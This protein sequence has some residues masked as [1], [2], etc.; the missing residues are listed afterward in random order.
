MPT[1]QQSQQEVGDGDNWFVGFASRLDPSNIPEKM[2]QYSSNMRLQRGTAAARLGATRLTGSYYGQNALL[3]YNAVGTYIRQ[4]DGYEFMAV[5]GFESLVLFNQDGSV[6]Q[7][8]PYF[9]S[10]GPTS[11]NGVTIPL[12][13]NA[14]IVQA[15][16][17]LYIF[18]GQAKGNPVS[19]TFTNAAI[20]AGTWGAITVVGLNVVGLDTNTE[21][22][23]QSAS[24]TNAYHVLNGAYT[25]QDPATNFPLN[26]LVI[27]WY[28]NTGSTFNAHTVA[29]NGMTI[30]I[31]Y[32]PLVWDLTSSTVNVV[33]QNFTTGTTANV[34]PSDFAI[35]YQNRLVCKNGDHNIAVSDILSDTFDLTFN[36]F[37]VNVGSADGVVGF[38]PWINNQMVVFM[39]KSVYLCYFDPTVATTGAPGVNSS[40]TVIT[41]EIGC[42]ARRTIVNAGNYVFF[43]SAKGVYML[44]PQLDMKLVGNT[45]PLSEPVADIFEKMNFSQTYKACAAYYFNRFYISFAYNGSANNNIVLVYNTLNQAWESADTYPSTMFIDEFFINAVGDARKLMAGCRMWIGSNGVVDYNPPGIVFLEDDRTPQAQPVDYFNYN[46]SFVLIPTAY[47]ASIRSRQYTFDSLSEKRFTR[48]QVQTNN[49]VGDSIQIYTNVHDPDTREMILDY[50]FAGGP[51]STLRPRIAS[52]GSCVDMEIKITSGTPSIKTIMVSGIVTDRRMISQE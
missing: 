17:K 18:R 46:T 31:G 24:N 15:L 2:L 25:A 48:A 36:S 52:R 23:F 30:Q 35:Y 42:L 13:A 43:L 47:T 11:F 16:D 7:E 19:C 38:L 6:S 41:S 21:F 22:L 1:Q 37:N 20:P 9:R 10:A 44:T 33:P 45:L 26:K 50:T 39:K 3:T 14:Q 27:E 8:Y 5:A 32:S 28:N 34:P 49:S 4:T 51:D 29:Q 12:G 40:I